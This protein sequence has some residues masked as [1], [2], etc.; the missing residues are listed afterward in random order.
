M[1]EDIKRYILEYAAYDS[2]PFHLIISALLFE[3]LCK[4]ANEI[5]PYIIKL[6]RDGYLECYYHTCYSGD[7]YKRIE[8]IKKSDLENYVYR[9]EPYGFDEYPKEGGEYFFKTTEQE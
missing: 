7:S 9:N 2:E 6:Q 1:R 5:I 8:K 4:K 3:G